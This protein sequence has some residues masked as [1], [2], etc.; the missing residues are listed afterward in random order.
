[1]CETY[2]GATTTLSSGTIAEPRPCTVRLGLSALAPLQREC[3][4][5]TGRGVA[6]ALQARLSTRMYRTASSVCPACGELFREFRL[7]KRAKPEPVDHCANCGAFFFDYQDGEPSALARM[8]GELSGQRSVPTPGDTPYSCPRCRKAMVLRPYL[9]GPLV[10]RCGSCLGT[11]AT[12]QQ[13]ER[14]QGFAFL[15]DEGRK[16]P[17]DPFLTWWQTLKDFFF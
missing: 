9:E 6:C 10:F 12:P 1:M 5:L 11:F 3:V 14:L 15:P 16:K 17:T 8:V 4:M 13:L 7:A 2:C